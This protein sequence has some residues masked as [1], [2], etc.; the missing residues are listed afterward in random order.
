MFNLDS[1]KANYLSLTLKEKTFVG[2]IV[3]DLLLLLFLGRAY[4][5]SAFYPNL[6]CHD[7]VLLITFLFSLTFKSDFRVK[8]IEIVGLISLIYLGISIIFKFHPEGNLYIY[9]RQFMVF[10]Y[11]IQSYFIFKAV[12]GLKNGLQ[13]LVQIIAAIAILATI[14]QLG[15]IFYIFFDIDANPFSRRNYFSPLTVPSVITATALGLVFLKR[16]KKIGVFLLLLITSFSFGHDSAYLAVIIVLFFYFFISASLKIK[17]LVS[18]F[19]I[20]SC[21]GLWFFVASFTDGNADARLF[22]WNKLLTKITENFSIMYGNG[23]GIPYLSADVAKQA[24]DFVLVFKKPESIYLVPPHNSFITMLYHL[25]GWV[26]LLFYPIRRIF[27]GAQPV[28]N[29]LLKFL[30][31]SLVGVSIWA[32]FNVIL[33]LPHSSTY[34]WLIY[35]TLAFYLYKINIDDKKNHYK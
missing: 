22:Y 3:L 2:L 23:F 16:Y 32:S 25:G 24:N 14:L 19:A 8:A 29:N 15:Y 1:F 28:K 7:V 10:G 6:Y 34:F 35:F 20:L 4:T 12:A 26:L 13:I 30:L 11:L 18:T 27:Y 33:E 21:I 5:K 17:I 31:L 9:L